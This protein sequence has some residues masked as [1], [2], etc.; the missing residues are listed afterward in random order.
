M[1]GFLVCRKKALAV[2]IKPAELREIVNLAVVQARKPIFYKWLNRERA[3]DTEKVMHKR[4]P[5]NDYAAGRVGAPE[6]LK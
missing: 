3:G 1:A 2:I 4:Q 6:L 5:I